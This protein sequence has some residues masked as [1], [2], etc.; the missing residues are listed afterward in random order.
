MRTVET[1]VSIETGLHARP[2]TV[3]SKT[4]ASFAA[5]ITIENLERRT[6]PANAKSIIALLTAGISAGS[7]VRLTAEG[8]DEDDAIAALVALI[9]P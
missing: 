6:P 2:A 3:F 5:T 9:D 7:R 4:A 8:P 1:V